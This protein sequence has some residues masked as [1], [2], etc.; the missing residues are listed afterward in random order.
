MCEHTY[1]H[2]FFF[3]GNFLTSA[4]TFLRTPAAEICMDWSIAGC[5]KRGRLFAFT[6]EK[7][8]NRLFLSQVG[9][10]RWQ[11]V[12]LICRGKHAAVQHRLITSWE[13]SPSAAGSQKHW[14]CA[15]PLT[16]SDRLMRS[17]LSGEAGCRGQRGEARQVARV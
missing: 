4:R 9:R 16:I 10:G 12:Q 14:L 11:R 6:P 8:G 2:M 5:V 7:N 13:A 15:A 17:S 3:Q 1:T